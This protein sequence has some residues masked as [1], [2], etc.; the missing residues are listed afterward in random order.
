MIEL[1]VEEIL[2][3]F[4]ELDSKNQKKAFKNFFSRLT[5]LSPK[6]R[7][8]PGE[9]ARTNPAGA[10]GLFYGGNLLTAQLISI[11]VAYALAIVGS[12]VLFKIVSAFMKVRADENE[13]VAGNLKMLKNR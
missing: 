2:K 3:K 5:F 13:E 12:Y 1:N 6:S 11:V 10:D 7:A 9:A 4:N 8:V